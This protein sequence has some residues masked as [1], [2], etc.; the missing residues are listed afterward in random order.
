MSKHTPGPWHVDKGGV[1]CSASGAVPVAGG[2][3][4]D[5]WEGESD[6][7]VS[8]ANARMMAASTDMYDALKNLC[9]LYDTDE[10]CRE[11]PE[12]IAARAAL[13]KADGAA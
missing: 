9:A 12:Y 5:A 3:I 2:W 1:V 11:I 10:G 8:R 4:E 13:A 7:H 6:D